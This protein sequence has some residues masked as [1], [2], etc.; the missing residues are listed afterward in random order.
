VGGLRIASSAQHIRCHLLHLH[1]LPGPPFNDRQAALAQAGGVQHQLCGQ[2]CALGFL[3]QPYP[4]HHE[5][6]RLAPLSCLA[7]QGA[8][9][10]DLRVFC[11]GDHGEEQGIRGLGKKGSRG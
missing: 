11:R 4:F 6:L 7:L 2:A 1:A 8:D 5:C 3:R 10:L 9:E